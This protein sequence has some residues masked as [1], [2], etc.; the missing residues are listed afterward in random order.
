MKDLGF[1][2]WNR[3]SSE[4]ISEFDEDIRFFY[5]SS[6]IRGRN[7]YYPPTLLDTILYNEIESISTK[8]ADLIKKIPKVCFN[9]NYKEWMGF[10]DIDNTYFD[11]ILK[12]CNKKYID[13]ATKFIRPDFLLTKFGL[14]LCEI[15]VSV[16]IG[17]MTDN[18]R[19]TESFKNTKYYQYLKNNGIVAET[20]NTEN[21]WKKAFSSCLI[22]TKNINRPILF[23][24]TA[25]TLDIGVRSPFINLAESAGYNVV[26]GLIQELKI[27]DDGVYI[28][29]QKV[30]IIYTRFTWSEIK[31]YVSLDLIEKLC[32][33]D[34]DGIVDF[35]SPPVYSLF[36]NKK[37]LAL[38]KDPKYKN[39]F[40][41]DDKSLIDKYIPNTI[42]ITNEIVDML[43]QNKNNWVIKPSSEY[44]G[45][46]ISI[47]S[48]ITESDW[49]L[50]IKNIIQHNMG[51]IA[52]QTITDYLH[53]R[54]ASGSE[55]KLSIGGMVF[56]SEFA[57]VFLRRLSNLSGKMVINAA[58]GATY[59][60]GY[61]IK[62][63]KEDFL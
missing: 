36:D 39:L 33:A 61:Y 17:G 49:K 35:V 27:K 9:N 40:T 25:T 45:Y 13:R 28:D 44:G 10:L 22:N 59:A 20:E 30:D 42:I 56:N 8:M 63:N 62:I 46:G 24:C 11:F 18:R 7:Y 12:T 55:Y 54:D 60:P 38:L 37:N 5:R 41:D 6:Y 23:E 47:G 2:L 3:Y 48:E 1:S 4:N 34:N 53:I 58:Q 29:E 16:T 14:R 43:L 26:S 50:Q 51:Y 52:Q 31:K 57:G 15:N 32:N 19:Y 21:K